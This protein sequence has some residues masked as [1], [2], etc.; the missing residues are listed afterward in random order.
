MSIKTKI[1]AVVAGAI[2]ALAGFTALIRARSMTAREACIEN[3]RQIEGAR[4]TWNL[5]SAA[6]KET[7]TTHGPVQTNYLKLP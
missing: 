5:P 4:A 2:L 6:V 3:M 1:L 7:N